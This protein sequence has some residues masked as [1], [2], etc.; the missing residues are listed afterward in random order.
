MGSEE[1]DVEAVLGFAEHA[2]SNAAYLWQEFPL[3]LR[4]RFQAVLF[5]EGLSFDGEK[6]GTAQTCCAF[7]YLD[8]KDGSEARWR[9][10]RDS[11]TPHINL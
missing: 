4:Q 10:Q 11:K 2:L 1:L 6:F 8:W 3:E 7:Q 9:P 5:P